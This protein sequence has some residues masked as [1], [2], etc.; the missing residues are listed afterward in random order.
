MS[1]AKCVKVLRFWV[2][3]FGSKQGTLKSEET[4]GSL[5][6]QQSNGLRFHISE[7]SLSS[8][9]R[10][11][12]IRFRYIFSQSKSHLCSVDNQAV[13]C[14]KWLPFFGCCWKWDGPRKTDRIFSASLMLHYYLSDM[15]SILA[16][17]DLPVKS[18]ATPPPLC[19]KE[20]YFL[21]KKL[22]VLYEMHRHDNRFDHV[23]RL[24]CSNVA[25]A[26]LHT[27]R[28]QNAHRSFCSRSVLFNGGEI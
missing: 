23:I 24:R 28:K 12:A 4:L 20:T 5:S 21:R 26:S 27:R 13:Y 14:A 7:V 16:G 11:G 6:G 25:H 18:Q 3:T 17:E 1:W 8:S 9:F 19:G 10:K 2:F 15:R 22:D